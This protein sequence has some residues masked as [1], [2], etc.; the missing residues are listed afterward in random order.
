M[1]HIYLLSLTLNIGVD[2][3]LAE[4][5]HAAVD[6]LEFALQ[7]LQKDQPE[8]FENGIL[9]NGESYG[10]QWVSLL[11]DRMLKRAGEEAHIGKLRGVMIGNGLVD[12]PVQRKAVAEKLRWTGILA[13]GTKQV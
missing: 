4:T 3:A 6:E 8:L 7:A 11:A 10:A 2:E 12:P 13:P 5:R 1:Y 9:L